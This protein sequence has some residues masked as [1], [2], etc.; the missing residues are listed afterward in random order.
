MEIQIEIPDKLTQLKD[1]KAAR[2][3]PKTLQE[4]EAVTNL[5]AEDRN[6]SSCFLCGMERTQE[7]L[8]KLK[9]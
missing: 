1:L 7:L 5:Q 6:T 3:L 8:S 2:V 9:R 4:L